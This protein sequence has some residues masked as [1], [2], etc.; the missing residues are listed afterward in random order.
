VLGAGMLVWIISFAASFV[1]TFG[2]MQKFA[3]EHPDQVTVTQSPGQYSIQVHGSHPEL[4]PD[5]GMMFGLMAAIVLLIAILLGAAIVRRL[6]DS[7]WRG[8]IALVPFGLLLNGLA[9]MR[10]LFSELLQGKEP[11]MRLFGL[12]LANNLAYLISLGGLL[13]L[14]IRKG[15]AGPN[16][17]DEAPA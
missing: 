7:N 5:F 10:M 4:M 2:K 8:W 1:G 16:R 6:H 17:F 15:T 12:I 14:L 9:M 11:D 3:A 13:Y